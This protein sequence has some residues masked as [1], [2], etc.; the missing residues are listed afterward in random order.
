MTRCILA[1]ICGKSAVIQK[2]INLLQISQSLLDF[3]LNFLQSQKHEILE[4]LL[5]IYCKQ[6]AFDN[7]IPVVAKLL[8]A[9]K[10][11]SQLA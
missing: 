10:S 2:N 6:R 9:K 1:E 11:V 7:S 3:E 5:D 8:D 4:G